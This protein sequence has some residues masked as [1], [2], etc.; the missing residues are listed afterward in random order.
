MRNDC[1]I[2]FLSLSHG[3]NHHI[4]PRSID[5]SLAKFPLN[6]VRLT[7]R[8]HY[9]AH[10]LLTKLYPDGREHSKMIWAWQRVCHNT[11]GQHISS[12]EFELAHELLRKNLIGKPL[13]EE[14]K[15]KISKNNARYWKDRE[16][17]AEHIAK[18]AAAMKGRTPWNKGKHLSEETIAKL[19]AIRKGRIPWNKGKKIGH[20]SEEQRKAQSLRLKGKN[21]WTKGR[22]WWNNGESNK[23]SND[24]PGE[25]WVEGRIK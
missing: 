4:V 8:E 23:C 22:H 21:T 1:L 3:E 18:W 16:K 11:D 20:L 9:I 12:H 6:I 7:Y 24:C 15:K 13:S 17:S 10:W 5:P 14:H 2:H 19:S 25:G